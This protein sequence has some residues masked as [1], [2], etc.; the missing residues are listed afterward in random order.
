[1]SKP[2]TITKISSNK[3]KNCLR[4]EVDTLLFAIREEIRKSQNNG[5][6]RI[7]YNLPDIFPIVNVNKRDCQ[8]FIYSNLIEELSKEYSIGLNGPIN[9]GKYELTI[10]WASIFNINE[11]K[12]MMNIINSHRK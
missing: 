1:M 10:E 3:K 5:N 7:I 2:L 11:R 8:L 4:R 9:G 6:V 12:Y